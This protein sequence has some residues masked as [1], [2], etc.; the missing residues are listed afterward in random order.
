MTYIPDTYPVSDSLRE[1]K[2][3]TL[4]E[5]EFF[6]KRVYR[7]YPVR[8]YGTECRITERNGSWEVSVKRSSSC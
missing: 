8:G 4:Y 3:N 2:F 1:A 6:V 5:A 7:E